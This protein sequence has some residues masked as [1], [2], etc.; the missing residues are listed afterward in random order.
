VESEILRDIALQASGLLSRKMG[1]PSVFPPLPAIVAQQTY[2]NS[3]KYK[4][5]E[6][7]DRYRRGLYTFFRRTA[8]DPNMS[9]F[10]CPD[11]SGS[12]PKRDRSNNALQA[13]ATLQ[14]EVFHEAAQGF[15]NRLL[16]LSLASG[17]SDRARIRQGYLIAVGREP[18]REE[19]SLLEDL[20]QQARDYYQSHSDEATKLVGNHPVKDVAYNENAAWIA[21]TRVLLNLDEFLTRE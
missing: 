15:A 17:L 21:T 3:N 10:D 7:D 12:K 18:E 4:V 6:G 5:S 2:A 1:G 11:S 13:L 16:K 8:I 9:V 14:N 19:A 20:L